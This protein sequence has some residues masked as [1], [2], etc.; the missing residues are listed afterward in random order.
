MQGLSGNWKQWLQSKFMSKSGSPSR[1]LRKRESA[2][3]APVAAQVEQLESRELLTVTFHGGAVISN[4]AAQNIYLG[5]DWVNSQPLHTQAGQLDTFMKTMVASKFMDG[6]TVAGYNVYRGTFTPG[7][8]NGAALD[9]TNGITDTQLHAI[10]QSMINS[11]QVLEPNANR[12]YTIYVEPGVVI[13]TGFGSSGIIQGNGTGFLGYHNEFTGKTSTGTPLDIRYSIIAY[14]T[15][16]NFQYLTQGFTSIFNDLT[17]VTAHELA[18]AVTDPDA[19]T[20]SVGG[21]YDDVLSEVGD[22]TNFGFNLM[23]QGYL[24]QAIADKNDLP[25][26]VAGVTQQLTA[27]QGLS[28]SKLTATSAKLS[29]TT[30]G[31]LAQGYR[32]FEVNNGSQLTLRATLGTAATSFNLTGLVPG[33][34]HSYVVQAFNGP[35]GVNSKVITGIAPFSPT[36]TV[37]AVTAQAAASQPQS[38]SSSQPLPVTTSVMVGGLESSRKIPASLATRSTSTTFVP[39]TLEFAN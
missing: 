3:I 25:I 4:V 39:G 26:S 10:I 15:F 22:I 6:M 36:V 1:R 27:P 20:K 17:K 21:W 11:H 37:S 31:V 35:S 29:W 28:L 9:K 14:P 30:V 2:A 24:I 5:S 8:F 38:T 32:I 12:L 33:S 23:F 34:T 18:E 19:F 16:P 13:N 7:V